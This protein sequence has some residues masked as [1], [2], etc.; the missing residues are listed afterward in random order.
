MLR[1]AYRGG[2][3][4]DDGE[5]KAPA[6]GALS[7][8]PNRIELLHDAD[9]GGARLLLVDRVRQSYID[10]ADPGLLAF[11]YARTIGDVLD[12]LPP[13]RLAVTHV[14]GGAGSI[15][16]YVHHT[17]PGS[18]QIILEPNEELT[19]LVRREMPYPKGIRLRIRP[20]DGRTGVAELA[21]ASADV[22]VLDAFDGS[23]IPAEL[24][25][26]EFLSAVARVLRT[27]GILLAN[28][29]DGPPAM[30]YLRR[31]LAGVHEVFGAAVA[32][33]DPGV[34]KRRRFGNVVIAASRG[35]LPVLDIERAAARADLP[36]RVLAGAALT[37]FLAGAQ[38]LTDSDSM[39]SPEPPGEIWHVAPA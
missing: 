3:R 19:A 15:A 28:L 27:D 39:V 10:L 22:V 31:V 16:R 20:V 36:R 9:G 35:M 1:S 8:P 33:S 12:G 5:R 29:V 30:A 26:V 17:R 4:A 25:T 32:I 2:V 21:T 34:L 6:E 23:V 11:E 18:P 38:P 7:G 24:T 14:G 37:Q 13:G